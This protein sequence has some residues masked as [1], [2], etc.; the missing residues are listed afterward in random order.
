M[1]QKT[2]EKKLQTTFGFITVVDYTDTIKETLFRVLLRETYNISGKVLL[3]CPKDTTVEDEEAV[4]QQKVEG[5][6]ISH[7]ELF[8]KKLTAKTLCGLVKDDYSILLY[9]LKTCFEQEIL[10]KEDYFEFVECATS[11]YYDT[12][13]PFNP[14]HPHDTVF[15]GALLRYVVDLTGME[16]EEEFSFRKKRADVVRWIKRDKRLAI[17]EMFHE[18]CFYEDS[19]QDCQ[20]F[21]YAIE[22]YDYQ[23]VKRPIPLWVIVLSAIMTLCVAKFFGVW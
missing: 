23:L 1:K 17:A 18:F 13:K 21:R 19:P 7:G 6:Y 11:H 10:T 16:T 3:V 20:E 4:L 22:N 5:L 15:G 8:D 14:L 9:D 2:F 12:L